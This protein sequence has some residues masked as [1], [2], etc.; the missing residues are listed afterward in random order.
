MDEEEL[1]GESS[2]IVRS[3]CTPG[4]SKKNR[5]VQAVGW[6]KIRGL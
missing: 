1:V 6:V 4:V 3:L 5:L 2:S